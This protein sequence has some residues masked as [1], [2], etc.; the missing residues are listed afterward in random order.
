MSP[1]TLD[2]TSS[3]VVSPFHHEAFVT[4]LVW[5]FVLGELVLVGLVLTRR[6][7]TFNLAPSSL[8]EPRARTLARRAFGTLWLLDGV[9]QFQSA[10]PLG[11]GSQVVRPMAAGTP[12]W[13]H[14]IMLDAVGIWNLHPVVLAAGVAWLQVGLGVGLLVAS[15][16]TSRWFAGASAAW[17]ALVWLIGN[18]AGG[19]FA[20][21]ASV[22]FGWPGATFFYALAGIFLA[23]SP[24]VFARSF[25]RVTLRIVSVV[26]GAGVVL[27]CL[28]AA[29]FWRGGPSNAVAAMS[30]SMT[31]AAQ[32]HWLA[33]IVRATGNAAAT[34]G[35]GFNLVVIFWLSVAALGLWT[36]VGTRRRWAVWTLVAGALVGWVAIQDTALFGGLATDVNSL[37]PLAVLV[38]C[39]S[40]RL[41]GVVAPPR[42]ARRIPRPVGAG[43]SAV[44]AAFAVA[45]VTVT[46]VAMGVA[47]VSGAET[48]LFVARNGPA[49]ATDTRAP[50]FTLTDQYGRPYSLGEHRGRVTLLTFLD[51]HCWTDCPLL[52]QQLAHLRSQLSARA[53]LDIVA[54]A[55]DPY[56]ES[57]RNVR[58]FIA[59]RGLAHVPDFYFVTGPLATMRRVWA[60][61]GVAVI[62]RRTDRMS[63]HSDVM[64]LISPHDRLRWVVPDVPSASP[65]AQASAV[66]ELKGLLAG[67]GIR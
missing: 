57:L 59:T 33:A 67:E 66:A 19:L 36:S 63:I 24:T 46:G 35:G 53:R 31:S 3:L 21:G 14:G 38:G 58:V 42:H 22:L 54:V 10:M 13:L 43:A 52:A 15:G 37:L 41:A 16:T 47:S 25:S 17:A 18:G 45:M 40:P 2:L 30:R 62:M 39:A 55:A 44:V 50:H 65:S 48:A 20:R 5:I 28:P 6:I 61:Y 29:H 1:R 8:E 4:L 51:P 12:W 34:M 60:H 49:V 23:V 11:L 56:Y 32:P 7:F 9:L 27:Q 26:L 64:F